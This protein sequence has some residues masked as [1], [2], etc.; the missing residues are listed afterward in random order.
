[1]PYV[2][3][4]IPLL[5][6]TG[7]VLEGREILYLVKVKLIEDNKDIIVHFAVIKNC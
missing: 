5:K 4:V 3:L 2:A 1:M 7:G 6:L